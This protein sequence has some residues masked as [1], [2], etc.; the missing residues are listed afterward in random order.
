MLTKLKKG[1][2]KVYYK[3]GELQFTFNYVDGVKQ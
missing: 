3:S 1:E 2:L